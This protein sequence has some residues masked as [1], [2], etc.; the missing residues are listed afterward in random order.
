MCLNSVKRGLVLNTQIFK[1]NIQPVV[2]FERLGKLSK[3]VST[4]S[5]V[6]DLLCLK[7]IVNDMH[8]IIW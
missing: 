8:M 5:K 2:A 4:V 3:L 1:V 7:N 6:I